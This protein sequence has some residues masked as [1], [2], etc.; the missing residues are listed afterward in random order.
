MMNTG[1]RTF[2]YFI[3]LSICLGLLIGAS[4][5][6]TSSVVGEYYLQ[7]FSGYANY[8]N[9]FSWYDEGILWGST[10][11]PLNQS[12]VYSNKFSI[13]SRSTTTTA[14]LNL[15]QPTTFF[16]F[17]LTGT[18][19]ASSSAINLYFR[20]TL[21]NQMFRLY[22]QRGGSGNGISALYNYNN[23]A[24]QT[25][26]SAI[27]TIMV[28]GITLFHSNSSIKFN[29]VG[30]QLAG[31][32]WSNAIPGANFG[33][34]VNCK[35]TN[36]QVSSIGDIQID[37]IYFLSGVSN[38][39][40]ISTDYEIGSLTEIE[41]GN[42][43]YTLT[44]T[45]TYQ[46]VE[47][48]PVN[49]YGSMDLTQFAFAVA[50]STELSKLTIL[51][52]I[53]GIDIGYYDSSYYYT[54][55][56]GISPR[57]MLVWTNINES[58]VTDHLT[59]ELFIT[60]I[61]KPAIF[62]YPV[63]VGDIEEDGIIYMKESTGLS[64]VVMPYLN[65]LYD[66]TSTFTV[67][68]P[69]YKMWF[70]STG[71]IGLCG[72]FTG[73]ENIGETFG[74][75]PTSFTT[76]TLEQEYDTISSF[77]LFG[78]ELPIHISQYTFDPSYSNYHVRINGY[79]VHACSIKNYLPWEKLVVFD[80]KDS[81]IAIIDEKVL[82]EFYNDNGKL[83]GM[84]TAL[85]RDFDGNRNMKHGD[86]TENGVYDGSIFGM[87][88]E[89]LYRFYYDAIVIP[90]ENPDLGNSI[91]FGGYAK[92]NASIPLYYINDSLYSG[93]L[94]YSTVDMLIP[95][96]Y[97]RLF[98]SNNHTEISIAD[99]PILM[100]NYYVATGFIAFSVGNFYINISNYDNTITYAHSHFDVVTNPDESD[101]WINSE[102]PISLC[103]GD[104]K[105][106]YKYFQENGHMGCIAMFLDEDVYN[107]G[108]AYYHSFL[109]SANT[110]DS[111]SYR[112]LMGGCGNHY[113]TFFVYINGT[114]FP[115]GII[116]THIQYTGDSEN[117]IDTN[118]KNI[119]YVGDEVI[120][121]GNHNFVGQDVRILFNGVPKF[122]ISMNSSFSIPTSF[123]KTG[124]VNITLCRYLSNN[125]YDYLDHV[126]ITIAEREEIQEPMVLLE[127]PFSYIAGAILTILFLVM[128]VILIGT[129]VQGMMQ[130][131]LLKYVPVFSGSL[132]FVVSCLIGFF[133]WYAIFILIS[134]LVILLSVLYISKKQ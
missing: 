132:G 33:L 39:W 111:F 74:S 124:A 133:P 30:G 58:F 15:T 126:I 113:W 73:Y 40:E 92:K 44:T 90:V 112:P 70:G 41:S 20:N 72:D 86:N 55:G 87:N 93:V 117:N 107:I 78:V 37:D 11:S 66:G 26:A 27:N 38:P 50:T 94:V 67:I 53:N 80:F 31:T 85:D 105:V 99:F 62:S 4:K 101:M 82:F 10:S 83:N 60:A 2:T 43:T 35:I 54:G 95:D 36:Y 34:T 5:P 129:T 19:G 9:D 16:N 49:S 42:R 79:T 14:Y 125:S 13:P 24:I 8:E 96:R 21:N 88:V 68:E 59:I 128:P 84:I 110:T 75:L 109:I 57:Y 106:N 76:D 28:V 103:L 102:P 69:I 63:Y 104:Y 46:L 12:Y 1:N 131:D 3:I 130:S 118:P 134:I 97:I 89:F 127:P 48:Y 91:S 17:T 120:I 121:Y 47:K 108:G 81:P 22:F 52:H 25:S 32:F 18:I 45:E 98:Y 119:A 6:T 61:T 7:N 65:G 56:S 116:H 71:G 23:V 29:I 100:S 51:L 77:T 114:Y 64:S 115:T 122:F 123:T